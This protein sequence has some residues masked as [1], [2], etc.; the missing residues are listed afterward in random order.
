[1]QVRDI[2]S[3]KMEQ[4]A[5]LRAFRQTML[6]ETK[7]TL[8]REILRRVL[9]LSQYRH[10]KILL[11]YVSTAIEVDTRRL[12][13]R[14]LKDGKQV[15]VPRCVPGTREMEFFF[16]HGMS[17]LEPGTFGVLEPIVGRCEKM[18]DFSEGLCIVPGLGFDCHGYRLGYGKGYYD[19]F[20]SRFGGVTAG[21]CYSGCV[22]FKLLHGRFD[23]A[24]D[25]LVTEKYIRSITRRGRASHDM[26][27]RRKT[28][29]P[30]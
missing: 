14:A 3:Y 29:P 13:E 25:V 19:R 11:T 12:I 18:T 1:M 20:L 26:G 21:I 15:A 7:E 17:D 27:S 30:Q 5:R 23:R 28:A 4:R 2:R 9:T 6:P 22:R 24:V 8:D 16:I 10:C